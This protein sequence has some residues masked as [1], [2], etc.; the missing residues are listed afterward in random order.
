MARPGV[1]TYGENFFLVHLEYAVE[2]APR[3]Y[4]LKTDSNWCIRSDRAS[5]VWFI[6]HDGQMQTFTDSLTKAMERL[7][8]GIKE[9]YYKT[10]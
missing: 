5:K 7:L 2:L 1:P 4:R 9:G 6:I 8:T 3:G 10:S